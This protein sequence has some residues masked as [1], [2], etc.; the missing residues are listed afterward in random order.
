MNEPN[1][2]EATVFVYQSKVNDEV[3]CCYLEAARA[4]DNDPEWDHVATLEPRLWIQAHWRLV[5]ER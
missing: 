4:Y 5:E 2:L 3:R 1:N